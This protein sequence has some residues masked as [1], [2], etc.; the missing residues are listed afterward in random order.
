MF[1]VFINIFLL[2]AL[3]WVGGGLFV[4]VAVFVAGITGLMDD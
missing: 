2:T 3:L 1:E 4:S